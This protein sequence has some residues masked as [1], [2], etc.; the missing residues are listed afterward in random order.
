[1]LSPSFKR[2]FKNLYSSHCVNFFTLDRKQPRNNLHLRRYI[3]WSKHLE[4]F[5]DRF[6]LHATSKYRGGHKATNRE[7]LKPLVH[8]A[9]DTIYSISGSMHK[10]VNP[11]AVNGAFCHDDHHDKDRSYRR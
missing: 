3:I 2:L 9:K 11:L 5:L 7:K 10:G 1:M 4:A 8:N 6:P